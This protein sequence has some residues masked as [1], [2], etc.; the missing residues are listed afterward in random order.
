MQ[1]FVAGGAA[2]PT[3][4]SEKKPKLPKVP[5]EVR[6]WLS[7]IGKKGASKGRATPP[8]NPDGSPGSWDKPATED[9][10]N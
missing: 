1:N 9:M 7:S 8:K 10:H 4:E 5:N 3:V 6:K 2:M